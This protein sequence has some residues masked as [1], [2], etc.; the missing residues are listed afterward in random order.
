MN[1]AITNFVPLASARPPPSLPF[2]VLR[3]RR[4]AKRLFAGRHSDG[5]RYHAALRS[6]N[7]SLR[8]HFAS[9]EDG[10][11]SS[12]D[13]RPFY[14]HV[15]KNTE[16]RDSDPNVMHQGSL[17][18]NPKHKSELF[19]EYFSSVFTKDDGKCPVLPILC[20]SKL[21]TV[22]ISRFTVW[23]SIRSLKP[24]LSQGPCGIPSYFLKQV[25]ASV[26]LPLSIL[27]QWSLTTGQCPALFKQSFIKPVWKKKGSRTDLSNYR[28]IT[29][30]SSLAKVL[31]KIITKE[32][33]SHCQR[34]EL[35]SPLQYGFMPN[36]SLTSQLLLCLNDWTKITAAKKPCFI[37]YLDF[38]KAFDTVCHS[39]LICRLRSLGIDGQVLSW[40]CNYLSDRTQRVSISGALSEPAA[41]LSGSMQG[42][43]VGPILYLLYAN[44]LLDLLA[45][46]DVSVYAYADDI[47]LYSDDPAKLQTALS[48]VQ[49]WCQDW[50][51]C[52]SVNKCTV[53]LLGSSHETPL[54]LFNQ[55]LP[56]SE[57]VKDLGITMD[58]KL[59]FNMHCFTLSKRVKSCCWTIAKCFTSGRVAPMLKA[60]L[61][62]VRPK[63]DSSCQVYNS[64]PEA[65]SK[66]LER[67]QK[68]FTRL[69]FERCKL[70]K[71][72][73]ED[74]L[75]F[76]GLTT[77]KERRF[78]LDLSLAHKLYHNFT[79][80]DSL[81]VRK[82]QT[83]HLV[84]NHRLEQEVRTGTQRHLAFANRVCAA[85]N[86]LSDEVIE[87]S[88][89]K[90]AR[91]IGL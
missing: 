24:K 1:C 64:M 44:S 16:G 82:Q 54:Y 70:K 46:A 89:D 2:P 27:F 35:I 68:L 67:C 58:R 71:S 69:I 90:F 42:S 20:E 52:L 50:Q 5:G 79:F 6:Y 14:D 81:L 59:N 77:L 10:L 33:L 49:S 72:S 23:E 51:L 7:R 62:Y 28:P 4:R 29:L 39:K 8:S 66:A 84:H 12:S 80:C 30:C 48:I 85:W 56:Y 34:N 78:R 40:M 74:R 9:L 36:R 13:M 87:C 17:I 61:T 22:H 55:P 45:A 65:G 15:R 38:K 41:V 60:Y 91:C 19:S 53:L 18:T 73:Y 57:S 3:W 75:K 31:E 83:R 37:V 25:S 88:P 32:I 76:L 26:S 21:E 43:I 47:K 86:L 11:L 63:L